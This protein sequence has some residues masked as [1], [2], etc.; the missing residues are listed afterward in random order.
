MLFFQVFFYVYMIQCDSYS[1]L[2]PFIF[3]IDSISCCFFAFYPIRR[4]YITI[5]RIYFLTFIIQQMNIIEDKVITFHRFQVILIT[6]FK[7]IK[8]LFYKFICLTINHDFYVITFWMCY[9]LFIVIYGRKKVVCYC[10]LNFPCVKF[11]KLF[12]M[13][14]K[15]GL[16]LLGYSPA[17]SVLFLSP[18]LSC[19]I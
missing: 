16:I 14:F 5:I 9:T 13:S 10:Y 12:M 17:D 1:I 7:W 6:I 18:L 4:I 2:K 11:L 8:K 3:F 19:P 15:Y